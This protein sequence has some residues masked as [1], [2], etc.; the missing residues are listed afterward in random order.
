MNKFKK[1]APFI[2]DVQLFKAVS[3]ARSIFNKEG[4]MGLAIYKAA[5]YYK[6]NPDDVAHHMGKFASHVKNKY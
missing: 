3:F 2:D 5:K 6:V 4:K 1:D